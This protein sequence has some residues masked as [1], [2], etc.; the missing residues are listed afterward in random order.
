MFRVAVCVSY[1]L[2][3]FCANLNG[4]DAVSRP[5]S[6]RS[7]DFVKT[8]RGDS[9]AVAIY[10][11][12][13][14]RFLYRIQ[15]PE[16]ELCKIYVGFDGME[17]WIG[18]F[19][20]RG[21]GVLTPG[22]RITYLLRYKSRDAL[23][24]PIP[25]RLKNTFAGFETG[26][27]IVEKLAIFEDIS[28]LLGISPKAIKRDS[29]KKLAKLQKNVASIGST[30]FR[31][32]FKWNEKHNWNYLLQTNLEGT[33]GIESIHVTTVAVAGTGFGSMPN[34][35]FPLQFRVLRN[36]D[37]N[38]SEVVF[39]PQYYSDSNTEVVTFEGRPVEKLKW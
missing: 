36:G 26:K 15:I 30:D 17:Y 22:K 29:L 14:A 4:Q 20:R 18:G 21:H 38:V 32:F 2:M 19:G 24:N 31:I 7:F 10:E 27:Q 23:K 6:V 16:G 33:Y 39:F 25:A 12:E 13:N 3:C 8:D 28:S 34:Y 1:M 5:V 35:P 11:K 9:F 37:S